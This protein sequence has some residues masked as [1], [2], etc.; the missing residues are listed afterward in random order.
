MTDAAKGTVFD[1]WGAHT[2][3]GTTDESQVCPD[4]SQEPFSISSVWGSMLKLW[5]GIFCVSQ[6][7]PS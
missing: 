4:I 2:N 3:S 6:M 5:P 7:M 1:L